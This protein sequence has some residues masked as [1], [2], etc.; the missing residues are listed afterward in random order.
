[1]I[2]ILAQSKNSVR[3]FVADFQ[4]IVGEEDRAQQQAEREE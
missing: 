1:M 4:S 3:I 2:L